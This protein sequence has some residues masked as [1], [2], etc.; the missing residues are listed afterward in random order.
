MLYNEAFVEKANEI[1][2]KCSKD[3]VTRS[4][5]EKWEICKQHLTKWTQ[6]QSRLLAK[7]KKEK[8]NAALKQIEKLKI[9]VIGMEVAID[10]IQQIKKCE[11]II[12]TLIAEQ[13]QGAVFRSKV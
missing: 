13:T 6:S 5:T 4:S 12:D 7:E 11:H 9:E 3:L 1:I 2:E 10:L 8:L